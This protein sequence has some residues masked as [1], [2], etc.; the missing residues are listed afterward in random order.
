MDGHSFPRL[1]ANR[2]F[3]GLFGWKQCFKNYL[4]FIRN[5]SKLAFLERIP[6]NMLCLLP[7]QLTSIKCF[8]KNTKN[9]LKKFQKQP[10]FWHFMNE[11][12]QQH[13]F[14]LP[15]KSVKRTVCKTV[16]ENYV[17]GTIM[18]ECFVIYH[19]LINNLS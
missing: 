7:R 2:S 3:H 5:V 13:Y 15:K 1:S 19:S 6:L 10:S 17:D 12:S 16:Q 14:I 9:C 18:S 8:Q 11:T 4:F